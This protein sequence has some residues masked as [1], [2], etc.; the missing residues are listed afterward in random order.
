MIPP[1]LTPI[2]IPFGALSSQAGQ[3]PTYSKGFLGAFEDLEIRP[4]LESARVGGLQKPATNTF[5][6]HIANFRAYNLP[7]S[8][9]RVYNVLVAHGSWDFKL[10]P[11]ASAP[12]S[13]ELQIN[14]KWAVEL[15]DSVSAYSGGGTAQQVIS[16][17]ISLA[18]SVVG[19]FWGGYS[20]FF[21]SLNVTIPIRAQV[22]LDADE[23]IT[24]KL[25]PDGTPRASMDGDEVVHEPRWSARQT[26]TFSRYT[27]ADPENG[28]G[29]HE[30]GHMMG[31]FHDLTDTSD[32][33]WNPE[34]SG[35]YSESNPKHQLY[36]Y[37]G[38]ARPYASHFKLAKLWA[39][40]V[41]STEVND[42]NPKHSPVRARIVVPY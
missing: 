31:L 24:V 6:Q 12:V 30:F 28:N 35:Q 32:V 15:S 10:Q 40:S 18:N 1:I 17:F 37:G 39:D 25:Y 38:G 4:V 5:L 21:A 22:L 27:P 26:K 8:P 33:M 29:P 20:L 14:V 9:V 34:N 7:N 41:F 16:T 3:H 11:L 36:K 19:E 42:V 2:G 23:F 13:W